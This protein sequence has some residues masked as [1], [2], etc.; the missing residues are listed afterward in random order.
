MTSIIIPTYNAEK[1]MRDLCEALRSQTISSELLVIDSSSSDRTVEI[2]E[3][4]GAKVLVVRSGGL[5]P[6]GDQNTGREGC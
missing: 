1:Q 5:R 4:F 2:A 6:W 3:S